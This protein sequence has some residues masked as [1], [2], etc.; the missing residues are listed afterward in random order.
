MGA[1][2]RLIGSRGL[3][4]TRPEIGTCRRLALQGSWLVV[5]DG[6]VS[7]LPFEAMAM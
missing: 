1:R 7:V 5:R 4:M 3:T 6:E 2:C